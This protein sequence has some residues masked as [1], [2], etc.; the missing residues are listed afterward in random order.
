MVAAAVAL[1]RPKHW[2]KNVIVFAPLIFAKGLFNTSLVVTSLRAFVAFCLTASAVYILNDIADAES[3]RAHP[4]KRNRPLASGAI[5]RKA[6]LA[7]LA[8]LVCATA[9]ICAVMEIKFIVVIT[10]YFLLNVAYSFRLKEVV[11]LDVFLIA[12]G[13]M[14]RVLGGAFAIGVQVSSWIVLCSMFI[15]LFLGFA[16][17]RGELVNVQGAESGAPRRVLLLYRVEFLD[18]ML[19][20]AAAGAVIA[21]ALYTVAPRTLATFGTENLIYTTIFVIYGVFRYLYLIH[22]GKQGENPTNALTSDVPILVNGLLWILA[23]VYLIYT[24][25]VL[26]W[27]FG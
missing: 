8:L 19:T 7:I 11:L 20:I 2:I 4:E 1:L 9:F 16:K 22:S 25:G 18:Q 23:C 14:L 3:D 15:S 26:A 12:G 24:G 17:R 27:P 10:A 5:S 21:Y 6:A 13:F